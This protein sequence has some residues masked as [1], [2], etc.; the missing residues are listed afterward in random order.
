MDPLSAVPERIVL[1]SFLCKDHDFE[2]LELESLGLSH[3]IIG[4]IVKRNGSTIRKLGIRNF[5]H[6]VLL[7]GTNRPASH[8]KCIPSQLILSISKYCPHLRALELD[9]NEIDITGVSQPPSQN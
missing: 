9:L 4:V 1:Q 2:E 8:F 3:A 5:E 6:T 7:W